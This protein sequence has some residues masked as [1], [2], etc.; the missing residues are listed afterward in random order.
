MPDTYTTRDSRPTS[1]SAPPKRRQVKKDA[2]IASLV[3]RMVD[4]ASSFISDHLEA[5][6]ALATKY[7]KG[8]P[9]G[10]E[11]EGRS[12]VVMTEVRDTV[13]GQLPAL[14]RV[15]TGGDRVVEFGPQEMEDEEIAAQRTDY[16]N[17]EFMEDNNGP[18]VLHNVFKDALKLRTGFVKWYWRKWEETEQ[19]EYTGLTDE[20]LD[21]LLLDDEVEVTV[22]ATYEGPEMPPAEPGAL[23]T[24]PSLSDATV[25]RTRKRGR[26]VVEAVP[27]EEV[28]WNRTARTFPDDCLIV[29]HST[30]QRIDEL[31]EMGYDEDVVRAAA[32]ARGATDQRDLAAQ[33]REVGNA[34]ADRRIEEVQDEDTRPIRYDEAYV[35]LNV[36]GKVK[37]WQ[38]CLAG[39]AH[40]FLM[41]RAVSHVP[42][43][44]F[45][46]DPEPHVVAGRSTADDTMDLQRIQSDIARGTL[47]SLSMSMDPRTVVQEDFIEMRDLLNTER[48]RVIRARGD[49][50]TVMREVRHEFIGSDSLPMM[51]FFSDVK[52]NRTGQSR[53]SQGL[54]PDVLQSATPS[55]VTATISKA[56]ERVMYIAWVFAHTGMRTLMRGL[57]KTT[58]E[59][60][61][62]AR[63]VRLRNKV[64]RA[65][66][67]AWNADSDVVINLALGAGTPEQKQTTL[68]YVA[69]QQEK[70]LGM[71]GPTPFVNFSHFR[72]TLARLVEA[73]GYR[74][75][76]EFY[77][78]VTPEMEQQLGQIMQQ[79]AQAEQGGGDQAGVAQAVAQVEMVKAQSQDAIARE[80]LALDARKVELEDDRE[81]DKQ[82]ADF[83]LR[84]VEIEATAKVSLDREAMRADLTRYRADL[85]TDVERERMMREERTTMRMEPEEG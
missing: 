9:F 83:I 44:L 69:Q 35:H 76:A 3:G 81:R 38:V 64:V 84:R 48:N 55:A 8:E 27:P 39:D 77:G 11:E 68:A 19:A 59:N 57:L 41:K 30:E 7:Y 18:F 15:F 72:R 42:L 5:D 37:L 78:E 32:G 71:L 20:D 16:I 46:P 43:A 63:T 28:L 45:C 75:A 66:P 17:Y 4:E 26:L 54:D 61:D 51:Q 62:W 31:L 40:T 82:A 60:Q 49:V 36:D 12:K 53:A 52:A 67:R 47:D 13:L 21:I 23:P 25:E 56:Q 2:E 70:L 74:N 79:R 10:N 50:N 29:V 80:K 33:V 85:D 34:S 24:R 14:V 1:D 65:D 58:V 73:G 6:R 22:T